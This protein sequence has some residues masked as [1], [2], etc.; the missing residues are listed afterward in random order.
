MKDCLPWAGHIHFD[1]DIIL[2][3]DDFLDKG[4]YQG[5]LGFRRG[6]IYILYGKGYVPVQEL[7]GM[8]IHVC[9]PFFGLPVD[10]PSYLW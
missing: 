8:G 6:M 2:V 9:D 4:S 10:K 3:N 1:F 5:F 7:A